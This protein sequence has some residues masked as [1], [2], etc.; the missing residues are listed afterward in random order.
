LYQQ[1]LVYL[2]SQEKKK[3]VILLRKAKELGN[4]EAEEMLKIMEE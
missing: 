1:S 3:A 4:E 2:S